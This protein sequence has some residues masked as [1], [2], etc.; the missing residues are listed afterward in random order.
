MHVEELVQNALSWV[1]MLTSAADGASHS[2]PGYN[3]ATPGYHGSFHR[4][5]RTA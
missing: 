2:L 3:I 4:I 5:E 1:G